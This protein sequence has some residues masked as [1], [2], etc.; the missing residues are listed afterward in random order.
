MNNS[1]LV[2][3]GASASGKTTV[4]HRILELD[5]RFKMIRSVT[6][7]PKRND[8]FD[9]EYIYLTEDEFSDLVNN[10]GVVEYTNYGG[11][12]YG[13]PISE[14]ERAFDDGHIPLLILDFNGVRSTVSHGSINA[15]CVYLY[16]DLNVLEK[17]LYERYLASEPTTKK[18]NSF[19]TRKEQNIK[20][21]LSMPQYSEL[22]YSIIKNT[23]ITSVAQRVISL[24]ALFENGEYTDAS[25]NMS[26]ALEISVNAKAKENSDRN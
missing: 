3:A 1:V 14:I 20:D 24:F 16:D 9:E 12:F 21:Y 18:L 10:N 8:S 19:I 26:E 17:R 7:R 22:F 4:A 15:C 11:A 23:E 13:T 25:F 5:S 2:L 6:T